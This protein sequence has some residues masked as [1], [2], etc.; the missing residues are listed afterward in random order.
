MKT[1]AM[2]SVQKSAGMDMLLALQLPPLNVEVTLTSFNS[3]RTAALPTWQEV[4][5]SHCR[6]VMSM[7]YVP[8]QQGAC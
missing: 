7:A 2:K 5:V 6:Y 1:H 3:W 8:P 4:S